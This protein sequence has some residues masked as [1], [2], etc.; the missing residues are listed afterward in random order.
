MNKTQ[1]R[2]LLLRALRQV[3]G[4]G[5]LSARIDCTIPNLVAYASGLAEIP[6][7]LLASIQKVLGD[8]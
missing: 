3:G 6:K 1:K 5:N 8:E 7:G 2:D 4:F